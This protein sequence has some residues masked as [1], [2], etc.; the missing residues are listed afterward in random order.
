MLNASAAVVAAPGT[1]QTFVDTYSRGLPAC[2]PAN[3]LSAT[4]S[5]PEKFWNCADITIRCAV[6]G[7]TQ[8]ELV[9]QVLYI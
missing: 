8:Y 9:A 7:E 2:E 3:Y 5:P 6:A 4:Q 1:N